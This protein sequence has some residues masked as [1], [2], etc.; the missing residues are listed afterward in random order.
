MTLLRVF[1]DQDGA[2]LLNEYR[3]ADAIAAVLASAGVRFEQ[4]QTQAP[5]PP[6]TDPEA[7]L[8]A[9]AKDIERLKAESGYVTADVIR[10][11]PEHPQK[12]ELRQKF[13]DEHIH[14]ED[15]VRFFVEGQAVF[16]LHLGDKIY[17]T[18]CTAGDLI[19]VPANTPHW[20]DMGEEPQF[21]AIRLFN[22]SEGWVAHFTDSPIAKGYPEYH[23]FA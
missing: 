5:L 8:T 20:F 17:A 7:I 19:G 12:T 16:Y 2:T 6:A 4:W 21:A 14:K 13:L 18:L 3:D 9:Y 15:E 11:H 10:M 1:S 22:N 23:A